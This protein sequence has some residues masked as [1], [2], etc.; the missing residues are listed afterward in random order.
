MDGMFALGNILLLIALLPLAFLVYT[1][2]NLRKLNI[3]VTH[4][5]VI[6][7][8]TLFIVLLIAGIILR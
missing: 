1:L 3:S 8:F 7:E 5:R 2:S 4:P 6:V